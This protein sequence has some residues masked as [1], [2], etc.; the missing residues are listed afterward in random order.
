MIDV[1]KILKKL[2]SAKSPSGFE[3]EARAVICEF[4]DKLKVPYYTDALGNLIAHREGSGKRGL[5]DAHMDTT[6]FLATLIDDKGFIRFDML[7]GLEVS[8]LCNTPVEFLNGAQGTIS[9]EMKVEAKDRKIDSFFIDIGASDKASA[10]KIVSPGDAAV[11]SGALRTI[12]GERVCA[13]YLDNRLGCA[14]LL[15]ALG[16]LSKC[17]YD[18]Y[19]VFSAQEEV[20][21]RGAKTAAFDINPDFS[22]TV[23]VTDAGDTPGFD[24]NTEVS[25]GSGAAIKI[26]DKGTI[27][28]P[29]I[30]SALEDTAKKFKFPYCRDIITSGGTN[31]GSIHLSRGGVPTGGISIP[32]RYMHSPCE[33]AALSDIDA[34]IRL[35]K[36]ALD[37]HAFI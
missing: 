11:Y 34:C 27:A 3:G 26:M 21:C 5:I 7:G 10:S 22:I 4:L 25:L 28:H 12:S 1:T 37:T 6:G 16:A 20:G 32:L 15:C 19:F 33:V 30:V 17:D 36:E 24:G 13:P 29:A 23:D 8:D 35:L 2:C 18:L 14:V 9:C 31:A